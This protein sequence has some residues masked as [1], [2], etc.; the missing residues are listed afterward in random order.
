MQWLACNIEVKLSVKLWR[1][2]HARTPSPL[3]GCAV[4]ICR[5]VKYAHSQCTLPQIHENFP[6]NYILLRTMIY[7][8]KNNLLQ[9]KFF[10]CVFQI[11]IKCLINEKQKIRTV[12][13]FLFSVGVAK[14]AGSSQFLEKIRRCVKWD[15]KILFYNYLDFVTVRLQKFIN[16]FKRFLKISDSAK[17]WTRNFLASVLKAPE[18]LV[19]LDKV[20]QKLKLSV[21][22]KTFPALF[23]F[24]ILQQNDLERWEWHQTKEGIFGF[25]QF[26]FQVSRYL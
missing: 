16:S 26:Q 13:I 5:N 14:K 18:M 19:Q 2:T 22:K 25:I 10:L 15:G 23:T 12:V 21:S 24:W 6:E 17:L 20:I 3:W 11:A 7:V 8:R 9:R 1:P 4:K